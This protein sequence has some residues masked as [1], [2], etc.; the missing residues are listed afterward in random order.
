MSAR[1]HPSPYKTT[2][3]SL[4]RRGETTPG[5]AR[6]PDAHTGTTVAAKKS[7]TYHTYQAVWSMQTKLRKLELEAKLA[8]DRQRRA[9]E[10]NDCLAQ[11][12]R[13]A[14]AKRRMMAAVR[15]SREAETRDL[16]AA[17]NRQTLQRL[18]AIRRKQDELSHTKLENASNMRKYSRV[19]DY[20]KA[21]VRER[22]LGDLRARAGAIRT[23]EAQSIEAAQ[24]KRAQRILDTR[25]D[26]GREADRWSH[27]RDHNAAVLAELKKREEELLSKI[28]RC[29][30]KEEAERQR[31]AEMLG[32][33]ANLIAG[34]VH[35]AGGVQQGGPGDSEPCVNAEGRSRHA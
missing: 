31:Q 11:K 7:A 2:L 1:P 25:T 15:Q 21:E 13:E 5:A 10:T 18:E 16:T 28:S 29:R 20:V 12:R 27:E 30:A 34:R 19:L 26:M 22:A 14:D 9:K 33:T 32:G 35:P 24:Q 6:G 17:H 23:D 8:E 3:P 4:A